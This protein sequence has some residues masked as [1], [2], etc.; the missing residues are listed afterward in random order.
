MVDKEDGR[1]LLR[2][3]CGEWVRATSQSHIRRV[4]SRISPALVLGHATPSG[5]C[6]TYGRST[7]SIEDEEV[8]VRLVDENGISTPDLGHPV[9]SVGDLRQGRQ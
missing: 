9:C 8:P 5:V 4:L 6:L 1:F 2:S 3:L 7:L